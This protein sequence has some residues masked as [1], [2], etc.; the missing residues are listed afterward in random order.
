MLPSCDS[1]S[2]LLVFIRIS[3]H[4]SEK[5]ELGIKASMENLDI[6]TYVEICKLGETLKVSILYPNLMLGRRKQK[7]SS[8]FLKPLWTTLKSMY[9]ISKKSLHLRTG[10]RIS[11]FGTKSPKHCDNHLCHNGKR[12]KRPYCYSF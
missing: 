4:F 10:M 12:L 1:T 11:N 2:L 5:V 9:P 8:K 7:T 6:K 3:T